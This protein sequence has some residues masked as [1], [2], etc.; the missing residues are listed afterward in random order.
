MD[1]EVQLTPQPVCE[2]GEVFKLGIF[3]EHWEEWEWV[4]ENG[5]AQ[6]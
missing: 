6:I 1:G 5:G 3:R 4:M 2:D